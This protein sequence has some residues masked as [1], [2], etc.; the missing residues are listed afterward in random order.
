MDDAHISRAAKQWAQQKQSI[1]VRA[2]NGQREGTRE[3]NTP[4]CRLQQTPARSIESGE[5]ERAED[6]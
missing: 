1:E 6:Y 2:Y 4:A 5:R 3:L